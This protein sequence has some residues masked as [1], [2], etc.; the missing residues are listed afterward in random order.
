MELTIKSLGGKIV[1]KDS[2]H[3]IISCTKIDNIKENQVV[4]SPS[5]LYDSVKLYNLSPYENYLV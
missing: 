5:W 1:S 2:C 3:I 4:V